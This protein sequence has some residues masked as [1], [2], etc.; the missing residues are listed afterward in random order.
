[1]R[2]LKRL[3]VFRFFFYYY[4]YLKIDFGFLRVNSG[5]T[6]TLEEQKGS[7]SLADFVSSSHG[8][9]ERKLQSGESIHP[10]KGEMRGGRTWCCAAAMCPGVSWTIQDKYNMMCVCVAESKTAWCSLTLSIEAA[11]KEQKHQRAVFLRLPPAGLL[12][13]NSY[14]NSAAWHKSA[15]LACHGGSRTSNL[16]VNYMENA[17]KK[18]TRRCDIIQQE[19]GVW[20]EACRVRLFIFQLATEDRS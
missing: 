14:G 9:A 13:W 11:L 3:L 15:V 19:S 17:E 10:L 4:Y 16:W 1:M 12:L 20:T 8:S 5:E 6:G 18:N 7:Q 2:R